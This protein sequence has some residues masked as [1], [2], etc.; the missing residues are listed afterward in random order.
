MLFGSFILKKYAYTQ[1][2]RYSICIFYAERKEETS[3]QARNVLKN[4]KKQRHKMGV[5]KLK[6]FLPFFHLLHTS[7]LYRTNMFLYGKTQYMLLFVYC[8]AG[9]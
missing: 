2:V 3:K 4:D 7:I 8:S 5:N 1:K 9:I 6:F